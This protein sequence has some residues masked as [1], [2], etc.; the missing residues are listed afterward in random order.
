MFA[1]CYVALTFVTFAMLA[2][3]PSGQRKT[4]L[5]FSALFFGLIGFMMTPRANMYTDTVRFFDTLD[6]V[7]N[8]AVTG[9]GDAWRYLMDACGYNSTP[10]IGAIMFLISLQPENGFLTLLA[11][12]VDIGA[13]FYLCFKQS[14]NGMNK[15]S[16]IAGVIC[17]LCLFNFNA[18]VSGIRNYMAGFL[19]ICIAYHFSDRF[20]IPSLLLYLPLIL[21]HPFAAMIPLLYIMSTTY[22]KHNVAFAFCCIPLLLQHYIQESVFS[23]FSKFSSIP[24]FAS[25]SFKST[26]Y[27]GERAYI[28]SA[29]IFSR[30]RDLLLFVFYLFILLYILKRKNNLS[31]HYAGLSIMMA[32]FAA[33]SLADEQLFSRSVS[34]L[35]LMLIP[36]ICELFSKEITKEKVSLPI[37]LVCLGT[38]VIFVDNLR[39]GVRFQ[40]IVFSWTSL[41]LIVSAFIL[42]LV[43]IAARKNRRKTQNETCISY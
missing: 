41:V 27:F 3:L 23:L 29:S 2:L 37:A 25:L 13:G 4:V 38:I 31:R 14:N 36:F 7:R 8:F 21:I 11:A 18:G 10:V 20:N 6:E 42:L 26:Q 19:A 24:F 22:K 5:V 32:C 12:T 28:V 34:M 9:L 30:T 15:R 33:G 35:M 16:L 43:F 1:I 40:N 39:A 17:F